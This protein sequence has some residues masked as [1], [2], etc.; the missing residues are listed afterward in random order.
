MNWFR[1]LDAAGWI[2]AILWNA[3]LLRLFLRE[4]LIYKTNRNGHHPPPG[5]DSS[6]G[7]SVSLQR[8]IE[9]LISAKTVRSRK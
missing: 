1:I 6:L 4:L 5:A 2:I 7:Q 3:I 8:K 9:G